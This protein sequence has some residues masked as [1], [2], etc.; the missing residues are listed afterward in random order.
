MLLVFCHVRKLKEIYCSLVVKMVRS[1]FSVNTDSYGLLLRN[2]KVLEGPLSEAPSNTRKPGKVRKT[3][4]RMCGQGK[5]KDVK[6]PPTFST[7]SGNHTAC[8]SR[9]S[10]KA[11]RFVGEFNLCTKTLN[12]TNDGAGNYS[13][14]SIPRADLWWYCGGETLRPILPADWRGTCAIVQLAIPFS[15]AF[16]R[17]PEPSGR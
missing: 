16:E 2:G 7:V 15:L 10:G 5:N 1:S 12:V 14:L 8:L 6:I 4:L 17:K 9:R 13:A 11:T 3:L